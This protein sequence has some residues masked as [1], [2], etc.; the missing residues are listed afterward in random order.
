MQSI[1]WKPESGGKRTQTILNIKQKED[2]KKN[3]QLY[4]SNLYLLHFFSYQIFQRFIFLLVFSRTSLRFIDYSFFCFLT[5]N[6]F[7]YFWVPLLLW[8][9]FVELLYNFPGSMLYHFHYCIPIMSSP[10]VVE[11]GDQWSLG[12]C[13]SLF[14]PIRGRL[15][16]P[17]YQFDWTNWDHMA[18]LGPITGARGCL[19]C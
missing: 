17:L 14:R 7:F 1:H 8:D 4:I 3:L 19:Y 6:F 13:A 15:K 12:Q 18:F 11:G 5:F 16:I 2:G 9:H 10:H